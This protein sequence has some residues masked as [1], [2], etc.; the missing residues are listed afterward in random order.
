MKK[1]PNGRVELRT[2]S[3]NRSNI[4]GMK[5]CDLLENGQDG[6]RVRNRIQEACGLTEGIGVD[7]VEEVALKW[8]QQPNQDDWAFGNDS[9]I[10]AY[11]CEQERNWVMFWVRIQRNVPQ[12]SNSFPNS[13][14][15]SPSSTFFPSKPWG[16]LWHRT[17]VLIFLAV[18]LAFNG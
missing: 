14:F 6:T 17:M 10:S 15:A 16:Q 18:S 2:M 12:M 9:T 8:K 4:L 7:W 1:D 5:W 11:D 13:S 3:W